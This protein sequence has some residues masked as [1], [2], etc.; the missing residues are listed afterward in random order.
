MHFCVRLLG[1][2]RAACIL[3]QL[4][5][6]SCIIS[7]ISGGGNCV[8]SLA[9][10]GVG[11]GRHIIPDERVA[12]TFGGGDAR[13]DSPNCPTRGGEDGGWGCGRQPC[14]DTSGTKREN[15]WFLIEWKGPE[16]RHDAPSP[17]SSARRSWTRSFGSK[18]AARPEGPR[19]SRSPVRPIPPHLRINQVRAVFSILYLV[20]HLSLSS[21]QNPPP[22]PPKRRGKEGRD[23]ARLGWNAHGSKPIVS[24]GR[25]KTKPIHAVFRWGL[26]VSS[27]SAVVRVRVS[28]ILCSGSAS[29][30]EQHKRVASHVTANTFVWHQKIGGKIQTIQLRS[31][32]QWGEPVV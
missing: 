6:L 15:P 31:Y 22:P 30:G 8:A 14:V 18:R 25:P 26:L 23:L 17:Q 1:G 5:R 16:G 19:L 9:H 32:Q 20:L 10:L 2:V 13:A 11:L 29:S 27:F 24:A 12:T 7:K 28:S 21:V 4:H 3:F